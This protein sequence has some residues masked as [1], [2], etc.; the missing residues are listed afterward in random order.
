LFEVNTSMNCATATTERGLDRA[1]RSFGTQGLSQPLD[2]EP[3]L[4]STSKRPRFFDQ[5]FLVALD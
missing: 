5:P 3:N 4:M 2:K 1:R